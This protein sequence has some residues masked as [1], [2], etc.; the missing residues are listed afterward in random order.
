MDGYDVVMRLEDTLSVLWAEASLASRCKLLRAA[1]ET[2]EVLNATD[3]KEAVLSF[4]F[5]CTHGNLF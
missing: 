5:C 3:A 2:C 1:V 4:S